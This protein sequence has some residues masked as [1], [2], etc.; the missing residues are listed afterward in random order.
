MIQQ[1]TLYISQHTD[2]AALPAAAPRKDGQLTPYEILS[3]LPSSAT[4]AQQ[5]SA[6]RAHIRF[7][8]VD[9]DLRPNPLCT[10]ETRADSLQEVTM[11]RPMYH[12]RSL[13]NPDSIYRPEVQ[14]SKP[15]VG[16]DPLPYSI[17]SDNLI[18]ATLIT[19]FV[20]ATVAITKSATFIQRQLKAFFQTHHKDN[21]E[22]RE[23]GTEIYFQLFLLLQTALLTALI[24]FY[25][26]QEVKHV[27]F[28]LPNYAV[29]GLFMG[30]V[31]AYFALKFL[32]YTIVNWVFFDRKKN[33]QWLKSQ[34]VLLSAAGIALF[35]I[36][37]LMAY[38]NLSVQS[39]VIYTLFVVI[40]VELL[41]FYKAYHIFFGKPSVF[42]QTFLYLCALEI[43]PLGAL[44]GALVLMTNNLEVKF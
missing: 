28:A 35:P 37:L 38:S 34:L 41:A 1:D 32:A 33:E 31:L 5:D 7:E 22:V 27:S 43:M 23:T 6:I 2:T 10:P 21:A 39:T 25:Y 15:G 12:S 17:G 11:A 26:C 42:V 19:C 29:M 8:E 24:L 44:W 14:V 16:G 9:W 20:L 30:A 40:L 36:V 4:P 3:W 13:L 18:S